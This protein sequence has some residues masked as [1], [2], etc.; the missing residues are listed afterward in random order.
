MD[1]KVVLSMSLCLAKTLQYADRAFS[2]KI[3]SEVADKT[4]MCNTSCMQERCKV[5]RVSPF[6]ES[7]VVGRGGEFIL[8]HRHLKLVQPLSLSL[9]L[10]IHQS[11]Y[12]FA[13]DHL[14]Q[15]WSIVAFVIW[16]FF[17]S[18]LGIVSV[19]LE[20]NF[21]LHN[22]FSASHILNSLPLLSTR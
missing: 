18:Y 6:G 3:W 20:D 19:V 5:A 17:P 7:G 9:S 14:C 13:I 8:D 22:S 21:F 16:L 1:Y 11:A 4:E 10:G 15:L 2:M 12:L